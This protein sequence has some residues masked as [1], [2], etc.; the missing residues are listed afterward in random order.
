MP[1]NSYL[2]GNAYDAATL[3][4][5]VN[6]IPHRPMKLLNS[7]IF[8]PRKSRTVSVI[9][10]ER[11]G[12]L[13]LITSQERGGPPNVHTSGKRVRRSFAIPH[14]PLDD[15]VGAA[16][17]QD[18]I[19][20]G[21][22][23]VLA[24]LEPEVLTK[25]EDM[26]A[27]HWATR[28]WLMATAL[29]G[30]V[31]DGDGSTELFDLFT[32]FGVSETTV[33]FPLSSGGGD[34]KGPAADVVRHFRDNVKGDAFDGGLAFCSDGWWDD[35]VSHPQVEEAYRF[36]QAVGNPNRESVRGGF[37]WQDITWINYGDTIP[38]SAGT[39]QK[40]IPADTVR[41]IPRGTQRM[42]EIVDGPPDTLRNVNREPDDIF[43]VATELEDFQKGIKIHT[44]QNSFAICLQP[45]NLVKG[46]KS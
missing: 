3:I 22:D 15:R 25:L 35:F 40:L 39:S 4:S 27:D 37:E 23:A 18:L 33:D 6:R 43:D 36:Y 45:A 8:R 21:E 12:Q 31:L 10:E 29:R 28:E 42:F 34:L 20:F 9:Y 46:T 5:Y 11:N 19:A 13:R 17:I 1:A 16:D 2:L 32:L 7:G 14:F 26:T 44:E 41:F 24:A 38:N 30:T